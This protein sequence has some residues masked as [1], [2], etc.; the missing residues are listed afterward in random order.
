MKD[1][2]LLKVIVLSTVFGKFYYLDVLFMEDTPEKFH[3]SEMGQRID[4]LLNPSIY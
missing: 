1:E 3:I 2:D 4:C